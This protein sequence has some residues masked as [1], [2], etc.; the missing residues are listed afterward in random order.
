M[1]RKKCRTIIFFCRSIAPLTHCGLI[2]FS[3]NL[4]GEIHNLMIINCSTYLEWIPPYAG[5]QRRASLTHQ[6]ALGQT[7]LLSLVCPALCKLC[8]PG[9]TSSCQTSCGVLTAVFLA[10]T[11]GAS[12]FNTFN[13]SDQALFTPVFPFTS[14]NVIHVNCICYQRNIQQHNVKHEKQQESRLSG[15]VHFI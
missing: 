14:P 2:K 5:F 15:H 11:G 7:V 12:E 1:Q 3:S 8:A 4:V 9:H 10:L 6:E 13:M